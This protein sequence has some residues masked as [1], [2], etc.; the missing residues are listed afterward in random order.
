MKGPIDQSE[1]RER[2]QKTPLD[3][4]TQV[5]A[6]GGL[7]VGSLVLALVLQ[8]GDTQRS[9]AENIRDNSRSMGEVKEL[10]TDIR[11]QFGHDI[12]KFEDKHLALQRTLDSMALE[13]EKLNFRIDSLEEN[14]KQGGKW[15]SVQNH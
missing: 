15:K 14:V 13:Q 7:G 5:G 1:H 9:N 11:L 6:G 8:Q 12:D 4:V 3:Y 10:L 2:R